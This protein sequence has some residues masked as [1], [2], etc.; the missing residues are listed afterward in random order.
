MADS[1]VSQLAAVT[2]PASSDLILIIDDPN[3]TPVSKKITIKNLFGNVPSNTVFEAT[4]TA[5]SNV[6]FTGTTANVTANLNSTGITT[7]N[8]LIVA[9][10]H[11]TISNR[12]TPASNTAAGAQGEFA[13][14][15]GYMYVAVANNIWKRAALSS[16]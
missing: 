15:S 4:M 2:S 8:R 10:D 16:F 13:Y 3:G 14:D 12:Q 7:L 5:Q 1:K 6:T 9:N 11:I